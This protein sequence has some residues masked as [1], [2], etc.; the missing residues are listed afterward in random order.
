MGT[1]ANR[2]MPSFYGEIFEITL[3]VPLWIYYIWRGWSALMV[4]CRSWKTEV[5]DETIASLQL[6]TPDAILEHLFPYTHHAQGHRDETHS[7]QVD[8]A[9]QLKIMICVET[10][11]FTVLRRVTARFMV[12]WSDPGG[13]GGRAARDGAGQINPPGTLRAR[14]EVFPL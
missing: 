11:S 5:S 8:R 4:T 6:S 10:N 3:T 14:V 2:T 12:T 7:R 9:S 13:M 1:V